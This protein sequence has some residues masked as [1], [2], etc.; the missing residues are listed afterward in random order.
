MRMSQVIWGQRRELQRKKNLFFQHFQPMNRFLKGKKIR[1]RAW[2]VNKV[3]RCSFTCTFHDNFSSSHLRARV[4]LNTLIVQNCWISVFS[5]F[6]SFHKLTS[7]VPPFLFLLHQ[8]F[9]RLGLWPPRPP[10]PSFLSCLPSSLPYLPP[11]TSSLLLHPFVSSHLGILTAFSRQPPAPR[12]DLN[13]GEPCD[14]CL[15][16]TA[17]HPLSFPCAVWRAALVWLSCGCMCVCVLHQME[18]RIHERFLEPAAQILRNFFSVYSD[19]CL[20]FQR[21]FDSCRHCAAKC[22]LIIIR[23][24]SLVF[25]LALWFF[26]LIQLVFHHLI[27]RHPN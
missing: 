16:K 6:D 15:P 20:F 26:I 18:Q 23:L 12:G 27:S 11:S 10:H 2:P 14:G 19:G 1:W 3:G 24:D 25:V 7:F 4:S 22:A 8:P 21:L 13:R 5:L 17:R 9:F